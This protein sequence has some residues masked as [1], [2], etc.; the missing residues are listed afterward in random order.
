MRWDDAFL[1]VGFPLYFFIIYRHI[2]KG[3]KP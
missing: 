3:G 1:L 2:K